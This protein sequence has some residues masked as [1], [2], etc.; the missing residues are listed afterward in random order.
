[1]EAFRMPVNLSIK[2]VPDDLA[3]QLKARAQRNHRSMQREMLAILEEAVHAPRRLTP[4]ELLA[5]VRKLGLKT[6]SESADIIRKLRD[7]RYGC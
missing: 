1:M 3:A 4:T 5:E 7:E 6:P 2:N